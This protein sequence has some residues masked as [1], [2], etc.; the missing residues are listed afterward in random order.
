MSVTYSVDRDTVDKLRAWQQVVRKVFVSVDMKIEYETRFR[1]E[2]IHAPLDQL[3]IVWV[4]ADG[5]AV[6][7]TRHHI[8]GNPG[9]SCVVMLVTRGAVR[10][11]Q[12]G[13][14][15]DVVAGT[16]S[17]LDLDAPYAHEHSGASETY[18]LRVPNA[19][20]R[21]RFRE[22]RD[23]C[24]V[25]RPVTRGVRGIAADLIASLCR[26]AIGTEAYTAATLAAQIIDV[27]SLAFD[28]PPGDNPDGPS[29][30]R[31]VVR[32][33]ALA[34]IDNH[35]S[36]LDL[37][38]IQI[39]NA[40]GV[41]LR[42]LQQSF[43]DVESSVRDALRIR[44]LQLCRQKLEDQ[45]FDLL[46]ISELARRH[47]FTNQSHFAVSF[48]KEFDRTARDIRNEATRRRRGRQVS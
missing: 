44:R 16:L 26:H 48:R 31:N 28:A 45:R 29:I 1:G 27:V 7:R 22:I 30:A 34:Y 12:Y 4:K 14:T 5:E 18:F 6:R 32:R 33:R 35:F 40:V 41:S 3:D 39:A 20:S 10:I 47:G 25:P 9:D 19:M 2:M 46:R 15:A 36:D 43:A 11:S 8:T 13:R 17:A 24:A 21:T 37:G 38:P 42:Y 23:H